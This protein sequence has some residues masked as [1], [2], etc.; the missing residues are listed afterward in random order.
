MLQGLGRGSRVGAVVRLGQQE[1]KRL[2]LGRFGLS[3]VGFAVHLLVRAVAGTFP[4]HSAGHDKWQVST[5][6]GR[7]SGQQGWPGGR[8]TAHV[9]QSDL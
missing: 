3:P 9:F 6:G 1:K 4:G 5:P 8:S 7:G 2:L